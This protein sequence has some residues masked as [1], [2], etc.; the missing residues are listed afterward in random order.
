[1]STT[2]TP[3][4][5]SA[6]R[7][8]GLIKRARTK[9]D[10]AIKDLKRLDRLLTRLG[11]VNAHI[12]FKSR[13]VNGVSQKTNQMYTLGPQDT[14]TKKR[15]YTY[16]GVDDA[17]QREAAESISRYHIREKLRERI[18][19]LKSSM[20]KA[21]LQLHKT[22]DTYRDLANQAVASVREY[23]QHVGET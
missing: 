9:A 13:K 2:P 17:K 14:K 11:C 16:I 3:R 8:I 5:A 22:L 7:G 12:H 6:N 20:R 19:E 23:K 18:A 15:Q 1:M 21:D 4:K 10:E